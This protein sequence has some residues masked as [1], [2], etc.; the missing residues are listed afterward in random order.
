MDSSKIKQYLFYSFNA[1]VGIVLI[2]SAV[3]KLIS[4]D[5]FE[6]YIYSFDILNLTLSSLAARAFIAA[7]LFLGTGLILNFYPRFFR[8]CTILLL[9]FFSCFLVYVYF[10]KGNEDNC[11]CFGDLIELNPLPSILKN[12]ALIAI[13]IPTYKINPFHLR[14]KPYISGGVALLILIG[15]FLIFPSSIKFRQADK[16]EYYNREAMN[17]FLT[18]QNYFEN[19]TND[20]KVLCF[21]G[22]GCKYCELTATKLRLMQQNNPDMDAAFIGIFWGNE[23]KLEHFYEETKL[24]YSETLLI[25]PVTF[26]EITNGSMPIIVILRNNKIVDSYKYLDLQEKVFIKSTQKSLN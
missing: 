8:L 4:I 13:L 6:L 12:I 1:L 14:Y 22:I 16:D 10:T 11:H 3:L 23:A 20:T 18:E 25:N 17:E 24:T 21:F 7:E 15:I 9:I 2:V 19:T 26:L 5:S